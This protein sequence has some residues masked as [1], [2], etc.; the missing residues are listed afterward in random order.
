MTRASRTF[1]PSALIRSSTSFFCQILRSFIYLLIKAFFSSVGNTALYLLGCKGLGASEWKADVQFSNFSEARDNM[2]KDGDHETS[3]SGLPS[4]R[5]QDNPEYTALFPEAKQV[6]GAFISHDDAERAT[7]L[8]VVA[9]EADAEAQAAKEE[10]LRRRVAALEGDVAAAA[11][12][13]KIRL[14]LPMLPALRRHGFTTTILVNTKRCDCHSIFAPVMCILSLE[15]MPYPHA[16]LPT[17]RYRTGTYREINLLALPTLDMYLP[18][19]KFESIQRVYI[20]LRCNHN[21]L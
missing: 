6:H 5:V 2:L 15:T 20:E 14:M 12:A 9:L 3:L 7:R 16:C 13:A 21:L 19:S 1:L 18:L 11:S 10:A 4:Y 8:R 17:G